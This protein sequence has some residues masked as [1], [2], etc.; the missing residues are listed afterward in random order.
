MNKGFLAQDPSKILNRLYF[1]Q[2][3]ETMIFMHFH[4]CCWILYM[5]IFRTLV[6]L[7]FI[8]FALR[9]KK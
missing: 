5:L 2:I 3:K 1:S 6:D 9:T 7:N 4:V 8:E